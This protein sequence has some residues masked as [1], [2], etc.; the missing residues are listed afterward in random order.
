MARE[1]LLRLFGGWCEPIGELIRTTPLT[2]IVRNPVFDRAPVRKW[3]EGSMTLLGDAIHPITPNLGQGGGLAIEDAAVL[4]RCL[5]KYVNHT[6]IRKAGAVQPALQRFA[7]LRFARAATI[8]RISR[9]YGVV[10]Q[11]ENRGAIG[12][13]RVLLSMAPPIVVQPLLKWMFDYDAYG[14][15]I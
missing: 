8:A 6:R 12:M 14:V 5:D 13:R 7:A 11:W 15:T 1:Q 10:G 9:T 3:G 2:S 4:A